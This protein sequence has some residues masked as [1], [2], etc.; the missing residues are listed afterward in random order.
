MD[1]ARRYAGLGQ[2]GRDRRGGDQ[3]SEVLL[4]IG[5]DQDHPRSVQAR[6]H[7]DWDRVIRRIAGKYTRSDRRAGPGKSKYI[8]RLLHPGVV[9]DIGR[10]IEATGESRSLL[11]GPARHDEVR[12]A[13]TTS[14]PGTPGV[15]IDGA[16]PSPCSTRPGRR[17]SA[18]SHRL[19]L[20]HA[21][22]GSARPLCADV[23]GPSADVVTELDAVN[24]GARA[25]L[26]AMECP[27]VYTSVGTGAHSGATEEETRA[28]RAALPTPRPATRGCQSSNRRSKWAPVPPRRSS[29]EPSKSP[30]VGLWAAPSQSGR[31]G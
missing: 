29:W 14:R 24:G 10:V 19:G 2:E 15:L 22:P 8:G 21:N 11:D 16:Y 26:A 23:F 4:G 17:R 7:S 28:I 6:H 31:S 25:V 30:T 13:A 27:T 1:S 18:R 9:D 20:D 5:G 12:Y 3:V